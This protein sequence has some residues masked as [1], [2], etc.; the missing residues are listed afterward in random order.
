MFRA[1]LRLIIRRYYSV[2]TVVGIC[3][4]FMLSGYWQDLTLPTATQHKSMAYTN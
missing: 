2:Y 1:G 4:A 3:H